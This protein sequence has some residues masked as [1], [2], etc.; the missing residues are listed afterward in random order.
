MGQATAIV[1]LLAAMLLTL[2]RSAVWAFVTLYLPCVILFSGTKQINLPGIPDVDVLFGIMYGILGGIVVKG[3]EALNFRFGI[4]DAVI[5][6]MS[7]SSIIT[8][9]LTES[10]WTAV[11]MF[12]LEFMGFLMPYFLADRK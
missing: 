12:G 4:A 8:A 5:L 1:F 9:G 11:N 7:L 6:A 2:H 10:L 3:G